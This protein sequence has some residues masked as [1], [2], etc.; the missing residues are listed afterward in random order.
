MVFTASPTNLFEI[1]IIIGGCIGGNEACPVHKRR[2]FIPYLILTNHR[3]FSSLWNGSFD[4]GL[5][6]RTMGRDK[7]EKVSGSNIEKTIFCIKEKMDAIGG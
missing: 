7:I 6:I 1:R 5:L 4:F 3:F 2:R